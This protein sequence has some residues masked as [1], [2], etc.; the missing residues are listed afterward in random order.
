[1]KLSPRRVCVFACGAIALSREQ[2]SA[3]AAS[4]DP[5]YKITPEDIAR[6]NP[7]KPTPEGL[8]EARKC[9]SYDCAMCHGEHGDGKGEIVESMKLTMHDWHDPG[10]AGRQNRR[11]AFLHHHQRQ[12]KNDRGRRPADGKAALESG[13]SGAVD[14][15]EGRAA[16]KSAAAQR[17]PSMRAVRTGRPRRPVLGS[18]CAH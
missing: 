5:E 11:R 2:Q 6:K 9:S 17:F 8:A 4:Q 3:D 1:M 14:G 18:F 12:R 16:A 13:E 10:F 15:G 7:V